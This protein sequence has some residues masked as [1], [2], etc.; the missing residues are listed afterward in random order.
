MINA[1][2]IQIILYMAILSV[3]VGCSCLP[4]EPD[5]EAI[6]NPIELSIVQQAPEDKPNDLK[7]IPSSD[8]ALND[9]MKLTD[10]EIKDLTFQANVL[11]DQN[12]AFRLAI[13]YEFGFF[14]PKL[15]KEWFEVAA[16]LGHPEALSVLRES[17]EGVGK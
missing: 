10:S 11:G 17:E 6:S 8:V 4:Q 15:A 2:Q 14:D 13:A 16:S 7:N 12:A 5:L 9:S 3:S 1:E